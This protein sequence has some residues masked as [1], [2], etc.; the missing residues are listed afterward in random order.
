MR[1]TL[2]NGQIA[3]VEAVYICIIKESL[4]KDLEHDLIEHIYNLKQYMYIYLLLWLV[5]RWYP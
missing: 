1:R 5:Y 4:P 3:I 2:D